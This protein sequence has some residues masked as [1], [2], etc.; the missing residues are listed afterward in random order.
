MFE[1]CIPTWNSLDYLKIAIKAIQDNSAMQHKVR[2]HDNG[3]TDGTLDW[4]T[5]QK[6]PHTSTEQNEGFCAINYCLRRVETPYAMLMNADMY[7]F[8][9]WDLAI[10]RQINEFKRNRLKAFTISSCLVEPTGNNP[11]YDIQNFG[12]DAGTFDEQKLL[13]HYKAMQTA[14]FQ[15]RDTIQYSHPILLPTELLKRIGYLD[16]EYFPGWAADHDLAA[17]AYYRGECRHFIM[18]GKSRVYHFG[19]KTFRQLSPEICAHHCEDLF[20]NKWGQTVFTF[21]QL[22]KVSRCYEHIA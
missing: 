20:E 14:Y 2:V 8:P 17:R 16:I 18:L 15:R 6:I 5:A 22:L 13:R 12:V 19:S 11:E 10:I 1:I 7:P 21:R 4:L 9:G 3:S